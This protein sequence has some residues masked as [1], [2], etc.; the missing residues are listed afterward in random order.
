[1]IVFVFPK[2][3][4]SYFSFL[5]KLTFVAFHFSM[6]K[7][8][9]LALASCFCVQLHSQ[10]PVLGT[11]NIQHLRYR[12]APKLQLF[13]EGQLRSLDV[14]QQFHYWE[15]TGGAIWRP[16]SKLAVTLAGGKYI[17]Y[18]EGGNFVT[19]ARNNEIRWW[20]QLTFSEEIGRLRIEHR[21]RS[22]QRYTSAGFRFRF[23]NRLGLTMPFNTK[24]IMKGTIGATV[25]N[26]VFFTDRAPYFERNRFLALIFYRV[27]DSVQVHLGY[28]R[29]FDYR[30][31][32]ETG[33]SFLQ[34]SVQYELR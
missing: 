8:I 1:V 4:G 21:Y 7:L 13:T 32:D 22:E 24:T 2:K 27:S 25:S 10:S 9:C 17:T 23:R 19:P 3:I 30:I 11:W 26:E 12:V 18:Q 5:F 29:Q 33:R 14:Y 16:H 15:W 31:N 20:P 28:V 34:T 6:R